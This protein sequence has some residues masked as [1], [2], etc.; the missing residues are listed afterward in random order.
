MPRSKKLWG[1]CTYSLARGHCILFWAVVSALPSVATFACSVAS[2]CRFA[3]YDPP[4][5]LSLRQGSLAG[6]GLA[7]GSS[8]VQFARHDQVCMHFQPTILPTQ[9]WQF[10][11]LPEHCLHRDRGMRIKAQW[12]H[13]PEKKGV[14]K[15]LPDFGIYFRG[16]KCSRGMLH[17]ARDSG[18]QKVQP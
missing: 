13:L 4:G 18:R 14:A 6:R 15:S 11:N 16:K 5:M 2:L 7:R 1:S 3:A 8:S 12:L 10:K 17:K 9:E